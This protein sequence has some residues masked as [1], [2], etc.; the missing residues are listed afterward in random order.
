MTS[1][2]PH[3]AS[4][5]WITPNAE[6][7]VIECARVSSDPSVAHKP[8][9]DLLRYLLVK[10]HWSPFEMVNICFDVYTTRDI[11]R[12]IL[13]HWT[14]RPQEFS[15]R[16]QDISVMAK[17]PILRECRMQHAKNRQASV[18][19][20]DLDLAGWWMES[21]QEVWDKAFEVYQE[22]LG[23]GIAKEVA[24]TVL[25]EGM[26]PTRMYLN[27]PLRS[28][29]HFCRLRHVDRGAQQ[30]VHD[31]AQHMRLIVAQHMPTIAAAA[32]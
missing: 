32:F 13:R 27:A 1:P 24:R 18:K 26:T 28:V 23:A 30:E 11:G 2:T 6:R 9:E 12:Q 19:N 21:Q 29:I 3:S 15:Q 22:A 5:T 16:Y 25:P 31:I 10:E 4:L 7:V 8:D 14:I 17:N 20:D